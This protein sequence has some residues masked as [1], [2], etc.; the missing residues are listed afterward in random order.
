MTLSW[1]VKFKSKPF[2]SNSLTRVFCISCQLHVIGFYKSNL[3]IKGWF[4]SGS[5]A[6]FTSKGPGVERR[7]M[8]LESFFSITG[9]G[10]CDKPMTW[11]Y[12][13]II[14]VETKNI[15]TDWVIASFRLLMINIINY[16]LLIIKIDLIQSCEM[17]WS[18]S[19]YVDLNIKSGKVA[20][21]VRF[22]PE[23]LLLYDKN[24]GKY[25]KNTW[26]TRW[27]RC[28]G[29]FKSDRLHIQ[30]WIQRNK[31]ILLVTPW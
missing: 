15:Y 9:Y 7:Q 19:K 4:N 22:L 18:K 25:S 30:H 21:L 2:Y 11:L 23:T 6:V 3:V 26:K 1:P 8:G 27:E 16:K 12:R 31:L 20:S 29:N 17:Q 24:A 10:Y 5:K 14:S 13:N 28:T